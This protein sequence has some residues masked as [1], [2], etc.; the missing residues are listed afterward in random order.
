MRAK[1]FNKFRLF[2]LKCQKIKS[3]LFY[4][5]I[6]D[7]I[8]SYLRSVISGLQ[9]RNYAN[10]NSS[11]LELCSYWQLRHEP[12]QLQ[13]AMSQI[14]VISNTNDCAIPL[15]CI[16][17]SCKLVIITCPFTIYSTNYCSSERIKN[18]LV[19]ALELCKSWGLYF[20]TT[21]LSAPLSWNFANLNGPV[22]DRC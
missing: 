4:W 19:C 2:F 11:V 9:S 3:K 20:T 21:Q 1:T 22:L 14:N 7:L 13:T 16:Q 10:L 17:S 6:Y 15:I 18:C 8:E 12:L 5:L